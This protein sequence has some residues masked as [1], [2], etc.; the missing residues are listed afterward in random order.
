[1]DHHPGRLELRM[2]PLGQG[3]CRYT[4][5]FTSHPTED[6]LSFIARRAGVGN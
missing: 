2:E 3:R 5:T 6:F 1:M 4:N